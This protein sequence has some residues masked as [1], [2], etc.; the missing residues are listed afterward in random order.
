VFE[1]EVPEINQNLINIVGASRDPGSRAKIAV[2]SDDKRIDAV[3]ACVG[4]RG[5]RVQSVS[6]ELN[7]ERIDIILWSENTAQFV[8][9][10]MSPANVVSIVVDEENQSMDIAVEEAKLSQAIGK[11]GQNIRLASELTQWKLNV[12]SET[13]ALEKDDEEIQKITDLFVESLSVG[14]DVAVLL[15]QEGF[16]TI[17]QVAYVPE[18][19]LQKIDGFDETLVNEL[20][21]RA[22]DQ[23]LLEAISTEENLEEHGPSDDLLALKTVS[24]EMAYSLAR[25]GINTKNLLAEQSIDELIEIDDI[26]EEMA[27]SMIS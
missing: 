19:E 4:M 13:E 3:G 18:K 15:A 25:G 26:D 1:I 14:D 22:Q 11:G 23:L 20:R 9:N 21:E 5:S 2:R 10:A 12:L 7:G 24:E 17:E 8:V 6:N 27:S 16:T